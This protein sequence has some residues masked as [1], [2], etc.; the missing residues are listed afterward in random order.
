MRII[1]RRSEKAEL[2]HCDKSK[3]SELVCVYGRRRVG[4]T[5]LIEQTFGSYFAFRA[6]GVES[7]N[8]RQQL[9]AFNQR[10]IECGDDTKRIPKDWFEAFSRLDKVLS[11]D[12][13]LLSPNGKKVVFL[14]EFPWFATPRS[15]FLMAFGEFWN[16]RGTASGN[17][18]FIMC[19]SATSWIIKNVLNDT[20]TLYHRVTAQIFLS[21][22]SLRE[23]EEFFNDRQFDWTREQIAEFQMVFGGLPFFMDLMN[24]DESFRQN[25]DRLLFRPAALLKNESNR[26]LEATLSKSP[27]YKQILELLSRH[28]YGMKKADCQQALGIAD[29]TFS[30][31]IENLIRC[32]YVVDHKQ[33]HEKNLP[34]YIQLIDSFLLFHYYFLS[35][36]DAIS[37]YEE[38]VNNTGTFS[39]WRGHAFEVLCLQHIDQLKA[40]LGISG[41]KTTQ[42]PWM[43]SETG[44]EGQVDLVIERE[45]KITNL[46]EMKYT[47]RPFAMD[48][49]EEQKLLKN[50]DIFREISGTKQT[51]RLVLVSAAGVAGTAHQEHISKVITL[52][53]LFE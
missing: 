26:L 4:K 36:N 34:C 33:K 51:L 5:F 12:D 2:E 29:G 38:L 24:G 25:V 3:K 47:D 11:K 31:A 46:C 23:T 16:R 32:G 1:G 49:S 19:G 43:C 14:D 40:A 45:D 22:F 20:G 50:R 17:Y 27:V 10:L 48:K 21:P 42:Y 37:G 30:R 9:R 52:D 15:D 6:T 39:N 41:V 8:T 18:L 13:V 7:G 35:K 28:M 44:K 53:D